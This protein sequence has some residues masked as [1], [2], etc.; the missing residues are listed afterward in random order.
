MDIHIRIKTKEGPIFWYHQGEEGSENFLAEG[1]TLIAQDPYG[2]E[3]LRG[4]SFSSWSAAK[5]AAKDAKTLVRWNNFDI[6][7]V[8]FWTLENGEEVPVKPE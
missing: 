6:K 7:N 4:T 1:D 8:T 2:D 3:Y 5:E